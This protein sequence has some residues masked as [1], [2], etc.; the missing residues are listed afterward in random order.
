MSNCFPHHTFFFFFLVP[1]LFVA[2]SL[3]LVLAHLFN[4]HNTVDN[5][6]ASITPGVGDSPHCIWRR[7]GGRNHLLQE[8]YKMDQGIGGPAP[9]WNSIWLYR[10][11]KS[12][13]LPI[14]AV[15]VRK[16]RCVTFLKRRVNVLTAFMA[17]CRVVTVGS[18]RYRGQNNNWVIIKVISKAR[19][20]CA[21]S[22][23]CL[24]IKSFDQS[25]HQP[26]RL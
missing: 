9:L 20:L 11:L 26:L 6:S 2:I 10:E 18:E 3:V 16:V 13:K 22:S 23:V 8:S 21:E 4:R 24:L 12:P 1:Y 25:G 15:C 14:R 5:L 19:W 7:S 17:R